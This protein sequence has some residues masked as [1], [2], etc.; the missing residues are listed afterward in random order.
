MVTVH[1]VLQRKARQT[2]CRVSPE[3]SIF[4]T[5][6]V[7]ADQNIGAVLVMDKDV[8]LGI[9]S[10]RDY[11]R[12]V[13]LHGLTSVST[14]VRAVMSKQIVYVNPDDT[15]DTCMA[16]MTNRHVRHLPVLNEER[17]VIGLVSIGDVVSSIIS[18]QQHT[19]EQLERYIY[20]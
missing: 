17:K 3:T 14:P 20:Q 16:L 13:V 15:I 2:L 1:Q 12:R 4:S 5:L 8:L 19:I 18:H 10:E 7:M 9:F 6:Q 11:A